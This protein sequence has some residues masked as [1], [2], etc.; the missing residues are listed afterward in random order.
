[1]PE[2]SAPI[3]PELAKAGICTPLTTILGISEILAIDILL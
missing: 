3:Y 1:L 2:A